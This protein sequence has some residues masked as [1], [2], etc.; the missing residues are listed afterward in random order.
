MSL[1]EM[2]ARAGLV[3]ATLNYCVRT[4]AKPEFHA[5]DHGRDNIVFDPRPVMVQ[6][7]RALA[8]QPTLA[9]DGFALVRHP[10]KVSDFHD[11]SQ[12]VGVYLEEV[13]SLILELTGAKRVEVLPGGGMVRYSERSP[14]YG[15]GENTG[16]ARFP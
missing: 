13:R 5:Q 4:A 2:D 3:P 14:R 6:D 9:K 15:G 10:T 1:A 12:V 16:P 8:E 7:G 11:R